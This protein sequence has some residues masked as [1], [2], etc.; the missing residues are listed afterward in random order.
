MAPTPDGEQLLVTLSAG[1]S[2]LAVDPQSFEELGRVPMG[3][4]PRG[5]VFAHGR[6]WTTTWLDNALEGF[7]WPVLPGATS[8]VVLDLRDDP[9]PEE[10]KVGQRLFNDADFSETRSFS[11]NNCHID[12]L[13]D[14]L[15]WDLLADGNVNTLAFR[16]IAGTEP[17]LWG[18]Q[19]PT[20]FDFSREVLK[21]VGAEATGEQME[22]LTVYM[23]SVTAPPNPYALPGGKLTESARRGEALFHGSVSA[24]GAACGACHSGPLFTNQTS[25]GGKTAGMNTD[26]PALIG[27]YDTAP[28]GRQGQWRTLDEMVEYAVEFTGAELSESELSDLNAFVYQIP[29]DSLYLNGAR[30]LSGADHVWFESPV[31]LTFSQALVPGQESLFSLRHVS[32]G[33]SEPVAGRWVLSGRV[34]RFVPQGDLQLEESYVIDVEPGLASSLGQMLYEPIQL[35]W[36][37]GGLPELDV[38]GK[39]GAELVVSGEVLDDLIG[40]PYDFVAEGVFAMIQ[41]TGGNVTGVVTTEI[42]EAT[43]DHVEGVTSGE[44]LVLE[45][46]R[47]G[48]V[49]G[50]IYVD[51]GHFEMIDEDG[52]GWADVGEGA[53]ASLGFE[54][55][56]TIW[57]I[58]TPGDE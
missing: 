51:G 14:G 6:A 1:A 44:V 47:F 37:V 12:G 16:N 11:C 29:G 36:R 23:Q 56:V 4:D 34:A 31:E 18:A 27:S 43:I 49:V 42:D 41:G 55:P 24:G 46:F 52:D 9:R 10:V 32:P 58:S 21:L 13:T 35:E 54:V 7:A 50:D 53:M 3:S 19:L 5:L 28:F 30:P 25:V 15:V 57:R 26:V 39:W 8:E 45:P 20:L 40:Y 2:V 33:V 38:S 17:F 22:M 48:S